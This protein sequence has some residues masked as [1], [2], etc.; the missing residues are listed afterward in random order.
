L[1]ESTLFKPAQL[2]RLRQL[3]KEHENEFYKAWT[4]Y[5]N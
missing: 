1:S 4:A 2:R 3:A 5:F